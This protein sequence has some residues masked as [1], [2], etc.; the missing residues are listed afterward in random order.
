MKKWKQLLGAIIL[1]ILCIVVVLVWQPEEKVVEEK[2]AVIHPVVSVFQAPISKHKGQLNVFTQVQPRW[3]ISVKAEVGAKVVAISPS[4]LEGERVQKG[5]NLLTLANEAYSARLSE[6]KSALAAAQFRLKKKENKNS[7]AVKNWRAVHPKEKA[8]EMAVHLPELQM[9]RE[10]VIAAKAKVKEAQYNFDATTITAPFT[11]FITSRN[12]GLGQNV[13]TGDTLFTLVGNE[14]LDLRASL[15]A[16]QW[17]LLE[18]N[19][20]T[21][22]ATIID[23]FGHKAGTALLKRG[24]GYV[25]KETQSYRIF[26]EVAS[27]ESRGVLPGQFV[28][29]VLP[30]APVENSIR[31][32][33]TALTQDGNIWI[34][35]QENKL[36]RRKA[37]ILIREDGYIMLDAPVNNN[38][39]KSARVLLH[40]LS[41]FISGQVVEPKYVN[42][43]EASK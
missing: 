25:E 27:D 24:G 22:R 1:F 21:S 42:E 10:E 7:L 4:A 32:P 34:L 29:L 3:S 11:G 16:T 20:G 12:V 5:Q 15:D 39:Q 35:D 28:K 30:T 18:K 14:V 9:G 38:Q 2:E 33:E 26:L 40:P 23:E 19:W 17:R 37:Q 36:R 41:T 6:A 8:P 43:Q 31:V 13:T